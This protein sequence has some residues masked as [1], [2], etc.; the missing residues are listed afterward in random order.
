MNKVKKYINSILI[1]SFSGVV[2]SGI[3]LYQHFFPEIEMGFISCG[4]GFSNPCITVG[5]SEYS[6]IFGLPV[7]SYG[8]LYFVMIAFLTLVADYAQ[9]KFYKIF[10]GF[11]FPLIIAGLISD[12]ILGILMI[13]IGEVCQLCIFTYVINILLFIVM[14]LF[15]KNHFSKNEIITS[16]AQ[17]FKPENADEKASF[18]LSILFVFFLAFA[19]FTS[20]NII[21]MK[22][23]VVKTPDVQKSKLLT[24]FYNQKTEKIE[25]AAS[26]LTIGRADAKVK[27]YIFNDFL[28]SACYKLYQLEKLIIAKY[29]N[30]IQ[31]IYYHYPLDSACNKYMDD[32]V[33]PNSCMASQSMYAAAEAGFF[34]EY[35]YI[36]FSNYGAYKESFE[37]ENIKN[38]LDQTV[39]QFKIKPESRQKFESIIE[40]S[41]GSAQISN[42]IEFA[43][44]Q[45]IEATPTIIIA[46]RKIVGVPPKELL[47]SIIDTEL[48]K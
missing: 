24:N 5:Q 39:K 33:Y 47:E 30:K 38:N 28:C 10:C 41:S 14:F 48:Q 40:S 44:K 37:K 13:T 27:I 11:V 46:E 1:L 12:V 36:H 35:F 4:K 16:V 45:K 20:T 42:H 26:N 3:L 22:S 7:A 2:L 9:D 43:E 8:L 25:F 17:F 29:K 23:G 34:E 31:I 19:I 32:T 18:A 6:I 15:I 21:K